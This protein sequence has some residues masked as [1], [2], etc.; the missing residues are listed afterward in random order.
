MQ[1]FIKKQKK[2]RLGSLTQLC[3]IRSANWR[4]QMANTTTIKKLKKKWHW[5]ELKK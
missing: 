3:L 2:L 5:K 1:A 4:T